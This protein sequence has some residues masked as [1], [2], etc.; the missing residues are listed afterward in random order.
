MLRNLEKDVDVSVMI[1]W[2][3]TDTFV[4]F[5]SL[6]P[7]YPI[8]AAL[9][10]WDQAVET[11]LENQHLWLEMKNEC[12]NIFSTLLKKTTNILFPVYNI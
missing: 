1:S 12:S 5:T 10:F 6:V 3:N 7:L 8:V 4:L 9:A 11:S 2:D